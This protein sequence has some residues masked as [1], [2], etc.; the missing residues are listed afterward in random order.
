MFSKAVFTATA[1]VLAV[2]AFAQSAGEAQLARS[3]GVEP[4]TYSVSQLIR[5][6]EAQREN[7]A[8][9]IR[10]I[11]AN[12]QGFV[13]SSQGSDVVTD[14]EAQFARALG[15]E[16]GRLSV[17]ELQRLDQAVRESEDVTARHILSGETRGDVAEDASAVSAGE[18][19]L[20]ASLGV[21]PA[22]Y[23]LNELVQI[24]TRLDAAD[25]N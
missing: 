14:G 7:D 21:D 3:V 8:E 23:T 2:P 20:A 13:V 25:D 19:Q 16:P 6:D 5:L 12:P 24:Q 10:Y 17:N 11:K 4:G 22:N 9:R 15:V 1:L 18:A